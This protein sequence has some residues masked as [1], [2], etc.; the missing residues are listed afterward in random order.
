MAGPFDGALLEDR[1]ILVVRE[2]VRV[3]VRTARVRVRGRVVRVVVGVDWGAL[4]HALGDDGGVE[5]LDEVVLDLVVAERVDVSRVV[6]EHGQGKLEALRV[7]EALTLGGK[8]VGWLMVW[9]SE[10]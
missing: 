3:D 2:L 7:V 9:K 8:L 6:G 4:F 1:V 5:V 10:W